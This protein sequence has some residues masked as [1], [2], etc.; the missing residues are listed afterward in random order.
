MTSWRRAALLLA[1]ASVVETLGFGHL[2][3]FTPLYLRDLGV[4]ADL[5]PTWTGMLSGASFLLGLPLAPFWGVWADRYSRKLII[6]RST[7][8]EGVIFFLFS[9]AGEPWHLLVARTLVGFILG[10]TGVM[11]AMLADITP[12]SRLPFA[13]GWISA[14]GT[15]GMSI[16]PF[17]GGWALS[18][19]TISQLYLIDAIACWAVVAALWLLLRETRSRPRPDAS[20]LDLLRALPSNVWASR[21]VPPLFALYFVVFLGANL[22]MPFVPLLVAAVYEGPDL[23]LAIGGVML[24]VGGLSAV[25][26]PLL[27]ALAQRFGPRRVLTA[28]LIVGA[29]AGVAQAIA[30]DYA[31][32]LATRAVYGLAQGGSA[33]LVVSMIAAAAPE[34]RRGSILNVILFPGY[35]AWMFGPLL[36]SGLAAI[37]IRF[38]FLGGAAVT[39]MAAGFNCIL[40]RRAAAEAEPVPD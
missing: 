16:G 36:G 18:R 25:A 26:A 20:T 27:G 15:L 29:G 24:A 23:P 28:A 31:W 7:L 2:G 11:F 12:K 39:A 13:I 4:P 19:L 6:L 40:A 37:G 32:L 1:V 5:V 35:F 30:P 38:A 21:A 17:L 8:G 22:Q 9:I 3:A 33:P 34:D 14:G 10:N